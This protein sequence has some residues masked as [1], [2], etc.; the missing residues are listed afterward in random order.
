MLVIADDL[1]GAADCGVACAGH[2][3][4]TL[5]AL[6]DCSDADAD[7]LAIDAD[8][9][10]AEPERAAVITARLTREHAGGDEVLLYKKMDSTLRGNVAVELA[11]LLA[12]R[13]ATACAGQ[14][15]V[16]VLAPAFPANGRTTVKGRLL[17]RGVPLEQT[18]LW[19]YERKK[20]PL[21]IAEML[22]EAELRTAV[23]GLDAVR[24]NALQNA[25]SRLARDTDVLVC[26]AETDADLR[27][28]ADASITLGRGTVWAG[29][30]GLAYHLPSAAGMTRGTA[31]AGRETLAAGPT[32]FVVGS[33][34]SAS[35]EQAR[36]LETWPDVISVRIAAAVLRAGDQTP[37]WQGHRKALER[38][39]RAGV[40]V[41][42]TVG[43]D[44]GGAVEKD[45]TVVAALANV[46][47]P[48]ANAVGALVVTGGET[49]RAVFGDWGISALQVVG[50]VESGLPY[51]IA[52]RWR[53]RLPV[54]TKAGGFGKPETLIHCR[55]FLRVLDR[56]GTDGIR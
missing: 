35:R 37:E 3:L 29:S 17:V 28:I 18:E 5:V 33:G 11:A 32:L 42:V 46:V 30:A 24:G 13:R 22:A 12:V 55:E 9:R 38:A 10:A 6:D 2:G 31:V 4:R 40:D 14:R 27:A 44:E 34:A 16:V 47:R 15:I 1:T 52:A 45:S 19:K 20:P 8:T 49:A 53:R 25:M 56:Q 26:D 7:V 41:L 54:L 39:L 36:V 51:S 43:A 21:S 50:E 23:V 48:F